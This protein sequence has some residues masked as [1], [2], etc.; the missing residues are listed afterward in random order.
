[1]ANGSCAGKVFVFLTSFSSSFRMS[2]AEQSEEKTRFACGF[3]YIQ[4]I[5]YSLKQIYN[6]QTTGFTEN[7]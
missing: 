6:R 7:R 4:L 5:N 1:M 2:P 3:I